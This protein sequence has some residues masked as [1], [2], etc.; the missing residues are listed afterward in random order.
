MALSHILNRRKPAIGHGM[1]ALMFGFAFWSNPPAAQAQQNAGQELDVLRIRPNF[2]V[3][4]GAGGNIAVQ[5]GPEGTI[6]VNAGTAAAAGRVLAAIKKATDQPIRYIIDTGAD[7]DFVEGNAALSMAGRNIMAAGTEPLGGE[8]TRD[9][10][11]AYPATIVSSEQ[12]L[13]RMSAANGQYPSE[14]WPQETFPERRKDY[15]INHEGIQIYQE[16]SAHSDSDS[17]VLFRGSDVVVTGD[18]IDA[19][20]F[21]VIDIA[22][23]GGIQGEIDALNHVIDVSFRP[24]PFVFAEGGTTVVPGHGRI[25]DRQDVV[26]YRDMVV[27]IRDIIQDMIK[28]GMTL[29]QIKEA[30]PAKAYEREY[31]SNSGPWTTDNFVEAIYKGLTEK[32]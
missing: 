8:L 13:T 12:I 31:G 10:A 29:P 32:K 4:A 18:I 22:R 21:P 14:A 17:I 30:S 3:I 27:T 15:Y 1:I 26:E 19:N 23:G 28:R 16:P 24:M 25:Y 7:R 6:V 9:A 20:R 11:N 2:Y 5:T